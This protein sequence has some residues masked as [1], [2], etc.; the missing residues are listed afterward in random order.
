MGYFSGRFAFRSTLAVLIAAGALGGCASE[1]AYPVR[2]HATAIDAGTP[3]GHNGARI[4]AMQVGAPYRYGGASPRGFDCSGLVYY[5]YRRA[6]IRVPRTTYA[7][8]HNAHRVSAGQLR[9][10]DLVFFRL[11]HR[12]VSHVG[13]YTGN[14]RFVHAP[15]SGKQVTYS[16]MNDPYWQTRFVAAGRYD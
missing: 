16:V 4:A 13:I 3:A 2:Q 12:P 8:L 10:G 7:Q 5:A 14:N 6:G 15:S 9:P 11:D 1:P